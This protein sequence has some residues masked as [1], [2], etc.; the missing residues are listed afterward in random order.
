MLRTVAAQLEAIKQFDEAE[1]LLREDMQYEPQQAPNLLMYYANRGKVDIV[2]KYV[3]DHGSSLPIEQVLQVCN[4]ALRASNPPPS[5]EQIARA[6]KWFEKA[7]AE[8][9]DSLD[10][11]ILYADLL[12]FERRFD[13]VEKVYRAI[14]ARKDVPDANRG[15]VLNNLSFL[16]AMQGKN[17]DEA[18]K[19]IDEALNLFGPQADVLDTHGV[20][21][22]SKGDTRRALEDLSDC[23]IATE[24]KGIQYVHLAMAQT[25]AFDYPAARKSLERANSL[26][27]SPDELSP[28]EKSYYQEMLQKLNLS[29][30]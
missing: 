26:H 11:Q 29:T 2:L 5:P 17:K 9:P 1:K 16:L 28:L 3:D 6:E 22:L 4:I 18:V 7:R 14:L 25:A 12:D 15:A 8:K 10:V 23:V 27:F 19:F 30:S 13:D 21:Y 24:P 20:V